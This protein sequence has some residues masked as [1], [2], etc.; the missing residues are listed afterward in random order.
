MVV[1]GVAITLL[2]AAL[3]ASLSGEPAVEEMV[4]GVSTFEGAPTKTPA[5][6]TDA[7]VVASATATPTARVVRESDTVVEPAP[8]N[9]PRRTRTPTPADEE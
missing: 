3:M 9:K 7:A 1:A 4:A 8:T 5:T 2:I 6:T